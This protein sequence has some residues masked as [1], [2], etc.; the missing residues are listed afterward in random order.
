MWYT[1]MM[2]SSARVGAAALVIA[3]LLSACSSSSAKPAAA[4]STKPTS[5]AR[6]TPRSFSE[7][8]ARIVT[9]APAGFVVQPKDKYDT[10]PSD[11]A[12]AIRDDGEPNAGKIL[13]A[14]KFVRGYQRIWIGPDKSQIIVFI[15]QF[16]AQGGAR[17]DY[18][19]YTQGHDSK[20]PPGAY[21]FAVTDL[22]AGRAVG[23]AQSDKDGSAVRIF[24]TTGVFTVQINC[25]VPNNDSETLPGL[26][27]VAT[28][29]AEDQFARIN[30]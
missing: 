7:L 16:A 17:Q 30:Q 15:N 5:V 27:T 23:V 6:A 29:I 24:F 11:L 28:T 8:A 13:R 19:R 26:Q 9:K 3:A 10:G 12:K 20:P 22:P 1:T 14:E 4:T 18:A 25:N 2:R 21:K